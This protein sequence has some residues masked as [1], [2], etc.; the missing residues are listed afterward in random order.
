MSARGAGRTG[1][2]RR[3]GPDR[4]GHRDR[5]RP[6]Q[7][8]R[9]RGPPARSDAASARDR[10]PPE[11]LRASL[12]ARGRVPDQPERVAT[13]PGVA[14]GPPPGP[15]WWRSRHQPPTRPLGGSRGRPRWR[16]DGR[17]DGPVRA[18]DQRDRD[19]WPGHA[20]QSSGPSPRDRA[21]GRARRYALDVETALDH[22]RPGIVHRIVGDVPRSLVAVLLGTFTLRFST[23][24]TGGL[25]VNYLKDLPVHGGPVV[26][27]TVVGIYAALFFSA[28]L[29]MSTPFGLISDR[30][31]HHR[32]MQLGRCSAW[33]RSILD[34]LHDQPVRPRRDAHPRRRLDRCLG[35]LDPRLHRGDHRRGRAAARAGGC[36]F[37]GRHAR[38]ARRWHRR[39]RLDLARHR[40]G[41]VPPQCADLRRVPRDLPVRRPA[42]PE[43]AS[44]AGPATPGCAVTPQS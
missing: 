30:D 41:R 3:P 19:E 23:G 12:A 14:V 33:S 20:G 10:R 29:V 38:R 31:G 11:P 44:R 35:P 8:D 36:P 40:A 34:L 27:S 18:A 17:D 21:H 6:A 25:L 22:G 4:A 2:G 24:L 32:V 1:H 15:R 37:R 26:E 13:E 42:S 9:T 16:D 7:R 39:G 5:G 28:E 43:S